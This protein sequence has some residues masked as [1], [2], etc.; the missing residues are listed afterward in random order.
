MKTPLSAPGLNKSAG[1][2]IIEQLIAMTV[3]SVITMIFIAV[4]NTFIIDYYI[5]NISTSESTKLRSTLTTI[6]RSIEL[7]TTVPTTVTPPSPNA[8]GYFCT[9]NEEYAFYLG[10]E[11]PDVPY[12][13]EEFP[14]PPGNC[15]A[16]PQNSTDPQ[17][18]S[19]WAKRTSLFGQYNRLISFKVSQVGSTNLYA[20]SMKLA[21]SSGGSSGTGDDLLCSPSIASGFGSCR[22][23]SGNLVS[24]TS[25]DIICRSGVGSQFCNVSS[26][27]SIVETRITTTP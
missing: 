16:Y 9:G 26:L 25:P 23:G 11:V 19:G 6:E 17:A 20:I 18:V 22:A 1:F 15:Y 21:Y 10:S 14:V 4:L 5:G 3:F 13:M 8:P 7:S 27:Q 24:F 2:T 12:V